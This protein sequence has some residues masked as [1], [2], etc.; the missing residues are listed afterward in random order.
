[1]TTNQKVIIGTAIGV[2]GIAIAA[3]AWAVNRYFPEYNPF[4]APPEPVPFPPQDRKEEQKWGKA[5][6]YN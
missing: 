4:S 1:M 6:A 2:T 5:Y 3:T